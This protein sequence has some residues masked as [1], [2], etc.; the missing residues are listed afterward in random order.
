M[1]CLNLSVDPSRLLYGPNQQMTWQ[2]LDRFERTTRDQSSVR[3]FVSVRRSWQDAFFDFSR[4]KLL[5][6]RI[7]TPKKL[8]FP[9]GNHRSSST[10][11]FLLLLHVF[12]NDRFYSRSNL[13]FPLSKTAACRGSDE[14]PNS[15]RMSQSVSSLL[16]D[17]FVSFLFQKLK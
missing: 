4:K 8:V 16:D 3:F 2:V 14:Y 12:G 13:E 9:L 11:R 17:P 7:P 6:H 1:L 10:S 15:H 5:V